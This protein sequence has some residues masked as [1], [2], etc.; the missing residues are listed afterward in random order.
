MQQPTRTEMSRDLDLPLTV[1]VLQRVLEYHGLI[2]L[3]Q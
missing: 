3:G 1:M 2:M